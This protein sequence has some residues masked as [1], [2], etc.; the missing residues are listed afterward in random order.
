[1]MV[2]ELEAATQVF[3]QAEDWE[4][5]G[6]WHLHLPVAEGFIDS[7]KTPRSIRQQCIQTLIDR[8]AYL[9]ETTGKPG[10]TG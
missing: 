2:R 10:S 9:P 7:P 4:G 3:P 5:C 8:A 1:M 6:Y